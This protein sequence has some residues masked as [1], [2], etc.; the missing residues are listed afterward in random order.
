MVS[1]TFDVTHREQR[2]YTRPNTNTFPYIFPTFLC[3]RRRNY[4]PLDGYVL[5]TAPPLPLLGSWS[6]KTGPAWLQVSVRWY[7]NN[8]RIE[9][10]NNKS[11]KTLTT[12]TTTTDGNWEEKP[13]SH[14]HCITIRPLPHS[15]T[16]SYHGHRPQ[17]HLDTN[18]SIGISNFH[19][20]TGNHNYYWN[21]S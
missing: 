16:I 1:H 12:T 14:L 8:I 18:H 7:S 4:F 19:S 10:S 9:F 15:S 20:F 2:Y 11:R 21:L 17:L 13:F 6:P 3:M 5:F